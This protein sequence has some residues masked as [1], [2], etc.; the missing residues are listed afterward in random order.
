MPLLPVNPDVVITLGHSHHLARGVFLFFGRD[1]R[2]S[3]TFPIS[4]FCT[5][6]MAHTH[7]NANAAAAARTNA[8]PHCNHTRNPGRHPAGWRQWIKLIRRGME[9]LFQPI[10]TNS[11]TQLV[12]FGIFATKCATLRS[13]YNQGTIFYSYEEVEVLFNWRIKYIE[14]RSCKY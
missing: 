14:L 6:R 3:P 5:C 11:H 2:S 12:F 8:Q 1:L 13:I 4:H 10:H 9:V 7:L